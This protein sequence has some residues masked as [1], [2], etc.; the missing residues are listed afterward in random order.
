MTYGETVQKTWI[1]QANPDHFDL[2]GFLA[3]Q[4]SQF[5]WLVRKYKTKIL[6]GHRVFLWQ[7][8]GSGAVAESGIV[9]E[10]EV[11]QPV[12]P[13]TDD[14]LSAP[15]WRIPDKAMTTDDRTILKLVRVANKSEI[16]RR[17]W[18]KDDPLLREMSIIRM[19][20]GTNSSVTTEQ[21]ARLWALWLKTQQDWSY[22]ESVAALWVYH[23][24]F[25]EKISTLPG[26]PVSE[27]SLQ[28]GRAIPDV[29]NQITNFRAFDPR[30]AHS[31]MAEASVAI[32][33]VWSEFDEADSGLID[34]AALKREF[35]RLWPA[36]V[37]I[38]LI[39]E[40]DALE[41]NLD[42]EA[43]RL[44]EESLEALLSRYALQQ[45]SASDKP[46]ARISQTRS[47]ERNPL[48]VAIA[49]L[50]ANFSCQ[51]P[52]CTYVPFVTSEGR[53]YCEIHHVTPLAQGGTDTIDNVVCLCPSHHREAHHGSGSDGLKH[54]LHGL[55]TFA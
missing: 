51:V 34:V 31:G 17:D 19:P 36:A 47:F 42:A 39:D 6:P 11:V 16:L 49:K 26:S 38:S 21:A 22:A 33:G 55:R 29:Y 14:R 3:S 15:Y 32:R 2:D 53:P 9:A 40:S 10:T 30:N 4:P 5:T 8:L 37:S 43:H 52:G 35:Q 18:L 50:R 24:T 25:G 44:M 28:I 7:A 13:R 54:L 27:I 45:E 12:A 23:Q 20:N 46:R 1:F 48:V 41:T